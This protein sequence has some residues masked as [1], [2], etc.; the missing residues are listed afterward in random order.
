MELLG[1]RL[2]Q[3][4]VREG[5]QLLSGETEV[6]V[7][8]VNEVD[9]DGT[10]IFEMTAE[11]LS[12]IEVDELEIRDSLRGTSVAS[13]EEYL[14]RHLSLMSEPKVEVSPEWWGRLPWLPFRITVDVES[15]GEAAD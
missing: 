6:R 12:W 9:Y 10:L 3:F 1:L 8:E 2:L 14:A 11:G 13:A 4:E 5:F 15:P 7:S